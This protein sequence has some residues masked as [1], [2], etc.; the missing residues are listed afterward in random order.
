[1]NLKEEIEAVVLR[2]IAHVEG[3]VRER[4]RG[5]VPRAVAKPRKLAKVTSIGKR[6][7]RHC[8][9]CGRRGHDARNCPGVAKAA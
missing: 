8:G 4:A 5:I 7:V 1:M 6:G 2:Y 9:G 3:A